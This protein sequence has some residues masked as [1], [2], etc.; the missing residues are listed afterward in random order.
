MSVATRCARTRF[1]KLYNVHQRLQETYIRQLIF[2]KRAHGLPVSALRELVSTLQ[3]IV[4]SVG[5]VV[6][7]VK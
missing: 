7:S 2:A 1:L 3:Y 5:F 6:R 4:N